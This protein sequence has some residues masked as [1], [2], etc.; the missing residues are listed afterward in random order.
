MIVGI[1]GRRVDGADDV[2]RAVARLAA[3]QQVTFTV[4]RGGTDRRAVQVTLAE[5]PA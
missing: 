3:G 1:D 4:L 5:R 2:S